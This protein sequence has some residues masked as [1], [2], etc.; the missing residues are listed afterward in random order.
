MDSTASCD[1]ESHAITFML[2]TCAAGTVPVGIFI[3]K[4]QTEEAYIQGFSL[5]KE[6][7]GE[8][9]FNSK[10]TPTLFLTDQSEAEM[11]ALSQ[12]STTF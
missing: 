5:I 6:M 8:V 7:I 4:G 1:P 3:T 11:N 9:A 2:T 10:D 12:G